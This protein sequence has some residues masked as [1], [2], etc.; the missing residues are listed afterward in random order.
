MNHL[1]TVFGMLEDNIAKD[2]EAIDGNGDG[3]VSKQ[4]SFQ[5][6]QNLAMDRKGDKKTPPPNLWRWLDDYSGDQSETVRETIL[7]LATNNRETYGRNLEFSEY[8]SFLRDLSKDLQTEFERIWGCVA[9]KRGCN[10]ASYMY[11]NNF[12]FTLEDDDV[13]IECWID[14]DACDLC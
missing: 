2:F 6:Y 8:T 11:R 5:A 14:C 12:G 4:E 9:V 7:N 10:W 13:L 3:L 1:T